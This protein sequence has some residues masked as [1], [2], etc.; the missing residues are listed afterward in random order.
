MKERITKVMRGQRREAR[1]LD[2]T[3]YADNE[4]PDQ[5]QVRAVLELQ[6]RKTEQKLAPG[7]PLIWTCRQLKGDPH[8]H[9]FWFTSI[10]MGIHKIASLIPEQLRAAG[11]DVKGLG[12]S[13]YSGRKIT[14]QGGLEAGIP[15]PYLAK[16]AGQKA[17]SST[18]SYIHHKNASAKAMSITIG[19]R[20]H[21]DDSSVLIRS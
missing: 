20:A 1:E 6:R 15:G 4:R 11:V 12:I 13:G 5:C 21:G 17:Y 14:L 16:I 9:Q 2:K 19:R 3:L 7:S 10:R 8:N 18:G